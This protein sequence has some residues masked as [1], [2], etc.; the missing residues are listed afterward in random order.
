[1]VVAGQVLKTN[2]RVLAAGKKKESPLGRGKNH[3]EIQRQSASC[4][5]ADT[6]FIGFVE[7]LIRGNGK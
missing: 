6:R 3:E 7:G 1:M 4:A 5:R 2:K